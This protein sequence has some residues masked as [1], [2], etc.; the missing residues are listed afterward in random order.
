MSTIGGGASAPLT[1]LTFIKRWKNVSLTERQAAQA[2][3]IDL[4][5][6]FGHPT[7]VEDDPSGDHF[8]F[9]KGATK[10]GGGR[11]F[12]DVWKRDYFAWEYKRKNG[13]LDEALL[14]LIRYAPALESP[15]LQ[16]VCDLERFR[17]HTAWTNT[18]PVKYEVKLDDLNDP[19]QREVLRNVFYD[20]DKLKPTKTREAVT[21][22][23]ADKFS[24]IAFRLQGRGTSE[25]IA[26]FVNQLVFCFFAH[27]VKLLPDGLFPKLLKRASQNPQKAR[28]YF[29]KLFEAMESGGDFDLNDIAWFNG[30]LFDGRRALQLDEG[31]IG[32]LV[33]AGSLD[34]GLIDPSIFG[35][36]FERF[37]DPDKRAQIGAHYTDRDKIFKLIEPVILRPLRAE[38]AVA[39]QEIQRLLSGET[40]PPMRAKQRRRMTPLEAA[41]EV[42]S[43]YLERLRDIRILDPACG[44]GNF[45]YLA[46]QGVKDIENKA[47]LECEML[48]L[49]PRLPIIGPEIVRGIEINPLAAEL[50]RTTIWIGDIQWRLRNGIH[51]KPRPILRKLDAIECRDALITAPPSML[52]DDGRATRLSNSR[53]NFPYFEAEWPQAEFIVGNPPFLGVKKMRRGLGLEY[54]GAIRRTYSGRVDEFS[55][56]VCWWFEKA[57]SQIVAAKA[58]RAGLVATNSIRGGQNR[59]T[60]DRIACDLRIFEAWSDEPWVIEGAA[61]RVSLVCFGPKKEQ[62][63]TALD[64]KLATRINPDLTCDADVSSARQLRENTDKSFIGMQKSGPHDI[65]GAHARQLLLQPVNPNGKRNSEILRPYINGLD[66]VRR[67]RDIWIIDFDSLPLSEASLFE[68]PFEL[69]KEL[70]ESYIEDEKQKLYEKGRK[71]LASSYKFRDD[72]WRL[73]RPRPELKEALRGLDR[74]IATAE[75]AK[76][77]VFVWMDTRIRADKNV[78]VIARDD[79][80]SFGVLQSRFHIAWSLRLGTSLEDRP[81]YTPTTTFETFPFPK[82]LTPDIPAKDYAADARAVAIA[83]AA[84]RLNELRSAWL[85]PPDLVRIEPEILPGYPDRVLPK[86]TLAAAALRERTLTNLYNQRPQW[87]LEAHHDLDVAVAAA[88]GWPAN[89]SE[90]DA[91]SKLLELNLS[92]TTAER[93]SERPRTTRKS[94][95]L[96][97]EEARRSPQFKL[98]IAGGKKRSDERLPHVGVSGTAQRTIRSRSRR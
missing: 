82:G 18:V 5:T 75:V 17:I 78:T 66:I 91:L 90:E 29:N 9:E 64:G 14:Q 92:R 34:W 39:R 6:L 44:S 71:D 86:D 52:D 56:L 40:K 61:V 33:A 65:A 72:W 47:N 42:R 69:L 37:L 94:R 16:V 98:P 54:T 11:G 36:L 3:F 35:T 8:A 67:P 48:G 93:V 10:V 55:D 63:S 76:H 89:I 12:A 68:G 7:P 25:Q 58:R 70:V 74:A 49:S 28:E 59:I 96:T 81:R 41:E 30:G 50:A 15:P 77:R 19:S 31:D 57:R 27:S 84:N 83:T 60:L 43:R 1:P 20:P 73:W 21:T 24:T 13:N 45:L 62:D 32:L 51:A 87:L 22:D 26:H 38:W 46:L 80:S 97:P 79:A 23:A 88:Y 4:C 95:G 85:N 53:G 2:H